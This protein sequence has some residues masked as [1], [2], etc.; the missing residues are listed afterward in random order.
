V[1]YAWSLGQHVSGDSMSSEPGVSKCKSWCCVVW[2]AKFVMLHVVKNK[3]IRWAWYV[4]YLL[5][6]TK[7]K[8]K[9]RGIIISAVWKKHLKAL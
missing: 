3:K 5:V 6:Y 1:L 2:H 9:T 8:R 4:A 7:F